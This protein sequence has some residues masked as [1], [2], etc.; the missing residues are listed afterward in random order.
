MSDKFCL[1]DIKNGKVFA[2]R[3]RVFRGFS[4]QFNGALAAE[5][6]F[7]GVTLGLEHRY[8]KA[9]VRGSL[10]EKL[11]SVFHPNFRPLAASRSRTSIIS[12]SKPRCSLRRIILPGVMSP[13]LRK[14]SKID[15]FKTLACNTSIAKESLRG[16]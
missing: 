5:G 3:G 9:G 14:A 4:D 6:D 1:S 13:C 12:G 2:G 11:C 10:P 15:S 16:N 7:G 8:L